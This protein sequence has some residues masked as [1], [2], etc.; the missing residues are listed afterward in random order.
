MAEQR[1]MK[2]A[3][4]RDSDD[5][6]DYD[7]EITGW[8]WGYHFGLDD[9]KEAGDWYW[10]SRQIKVQGH[11]IGEVGRRYASAE[12]VLIPNRDYD[13]DRRI[14]RDQRVGATRPSRV[15]TVEAR[16][17]ALHGLLSLPLEAVPALVTVL[18]ANQFKY[19]LIRGAKL[20]RRSAEVW[21]YSLET[22]VDADELPT[23]QTG[24][25]TPS[26]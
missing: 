20:F 22:W 15:G 25:G 13:R 4:R 5:F 10:E 8:S 16:D 3:K 19:M 9:R 21:G 1:S 6:A 14:E 2:R 26:T 11:L 23:R 12:F 18:A 17:R 24:D 7:I